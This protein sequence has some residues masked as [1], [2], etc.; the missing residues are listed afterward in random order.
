MPLVVKPG[1]TGTASYRTL[2]FD[3]FRVRLVEYSA[4]YKADHW[5][6]AGHIVFCLDGEMTTELSDGRTFHLSKGM[7]YTVSDNISTHRSY[8]DHIRYPTTLV[9]IAHT[10][11][12]VSNL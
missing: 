4:G 8:S 9:H 6:K 7:S 11:R 12:M 3:D 1:V 10:Q 2:Q 5:C